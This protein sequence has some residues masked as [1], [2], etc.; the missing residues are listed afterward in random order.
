MFMGH[1]RTSRQEPQVLDTGSLR[2]SLLRLLKSLHGR[3]DLT[4]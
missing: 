1:I 4:L 3:L 2:C